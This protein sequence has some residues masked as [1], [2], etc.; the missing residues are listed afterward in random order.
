MSLSF[1]SHSDMSVHKCFFHKLP[2]FILQNPVW[3]QSCLG[4]CHF[5]KEICPKNTKYSGL[6]V[7]I[8][9]QEN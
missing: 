4:V 9:P 7:S 6:E 1:A 2:F 8:F 3:R 5:E